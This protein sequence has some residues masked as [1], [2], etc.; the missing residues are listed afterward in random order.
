MSSVLRPRSHSLPSGFAQLIARKVGRGPYLVVG[1]EREELE[2][3]FTAAEANAAIFSSISEF[4]PGSAQ[5]GQ[6]PRASLAIW[7]YP[8]DNA[9]D[10]QAVAILA[11]AAESVLLV[12]E[13]GDES[14][15]RRPELVRRFA[16]AGFLPDYGCDLGLL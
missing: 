15:P 6:G 2:R 11:G 9:G 14:A 8:R 5:N 16:E 13:P 12:P 10:E 1:S 7:F 4:G 3:Q